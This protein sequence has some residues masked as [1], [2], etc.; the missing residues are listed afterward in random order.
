MNQEPIMKLS[1][2]VIVLILLGCSPADP[3]VEHAKNEPAAEWDGLSPPVG[4]ATPNT[5]ARNAGVAPIIKASGI[6]KPD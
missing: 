4:I 3:T 1:A 5:T 6:R 2:V